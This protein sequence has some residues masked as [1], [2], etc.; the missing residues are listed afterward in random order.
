MKELR[1]TEKTLILIS[2]SGRFNWPMQETDRAIGYRQQFITYIGGNNKQKL[3]K[4]LQGKSLEH[5]ELRPAKRLPFKWEAKVY[6]LAWDEA[7]N[8]ARRTQ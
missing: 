1:L 7:K 2:E 4:E 8:L 5:Y 6:G 3:R